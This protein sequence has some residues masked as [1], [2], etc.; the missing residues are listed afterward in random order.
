MTT[1][2]EVLQEIIKY[3]KQV[4]EAQRCN[5][6]PVAEADLKICPSGSPALEDIA[7]RLSTRYDVTFPKDLRELGTL[8]EA[9]HYIV[10][11][12]DRKL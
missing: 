3:A 12:R 9:A 6:K 4:P 5:L 8:A 11:Y 7:N 2:A 10:E 1:E